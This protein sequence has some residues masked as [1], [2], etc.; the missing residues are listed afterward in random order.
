MW[1]KPYGNTGKQISAISCGCMRFENYK[2]IDKAAEVAFHAYKRGVNYFDTAP[3]YLED[4]SEDIL[5]AAIKHMTPGTF[6][7][8]TKCFSSK[9]EDID[10]SIERSLQRLGVEKINFFH[11]WCILSLNS[12]EGRKAGG[13]VKAA[14]RAKEQGLI[15]HLVVSSHMP[16][17]D[18]ETMLAEGYFEGITLGYCAINFP[19]RESAVK[20]AAARGMGVVTMNPLGGGLIPN[21]AKQFDFL[22]QEGDETVVQAALRFNVSNPN[23]TTALVGFATREH[24]DQAVDAVENFHPYN[25]E[26]IAKIRE[27][28]IGSFNGMCTG[29]GYCQPCPQ[30]IPIPQLMDVYNLALLGSNEKPWELMGRL[31]WHWGI[32]GEEAKECSECG[33]CE[34]RC[35]QHLPIQ[36]R[37]K[38]ITSDMLPRIQKWHA[39]QEA[40]KAAAAKK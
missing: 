34:T 17:E 15:E 22:R 36:E 12:W 39:E 16:S 23:I 18:L 24:V 7:T 10:K 20:A 6:Y 35:T 25:E 32:S 19:F 9:G 3:A 11:I 8:S 37:L 2:D 29:C 13:A 5:G 28:I 1:T 40:K 30:G 33:L 21:N 38:S 4:H 27:H 14:L 26:Q 31:K